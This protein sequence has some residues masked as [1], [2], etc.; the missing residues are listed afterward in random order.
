MEESRSKPLL[1]FLKIELRTILALVLLLLVLVGVGFAADDKSITFDFGTGLSS[2]V[3]GGAVS[4]NGGAAIYPKI[5][6]EFSY[7]W[8]TALIAEQSSG[9]AVLD[10]IKMDSNQ[11]VTNNTFS[12]SGLTSD[13]YQ[14]TM[15][16]G[17]LTSSITTKVVVDEKTYIAQSEP[18]AWRTITMKARVK[19]GRIDL[20]FQKYTSDLWAVN[21]LTLVPTSA[22]LDSPEFDIVV[23]PQQHIKKAGETAVYQVSLIP[24]NNYSNEISLSLEN[25]PLGIQ[26]SFQP[27]SGIPPYVAYLTVTISEDMPS[28]QYNIDLI[29]KGSDL[30]SLMV[31]QKI[32]LMVLANSTYLPGVVVDT[33]LEPG[34]PEHKEAGKREQDFI[35]KYLDAESRDLPRQIDLM[36]LDELSAY[37]NISG[38]IPDPPVPT[39]FVDASLRY[40]TTAGI[41]RIVVD[42]APVAPVPQG[43]ESPGFWG[44]F[45]GAMF[46]PAS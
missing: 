1:G 17:N 14:I 5:Y 36:A 24:E 16:S 26:T 29:A 41:I 38:A 21:S 22:P 11:G 39:S 10:L 43:K 20:G 4:V 33:E 13:Y 2:E 12:I 34:T 28:T 31:R 23:K 37:T 6:E 15:I 40:L 46:N 42:S 19:D 25:I 45:F 35:D 30:A 3:S 9:A 8:A 27:A 44:N 18:G 32:S 7:G